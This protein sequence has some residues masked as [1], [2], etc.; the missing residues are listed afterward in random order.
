MRAVNGR[1]R[2]ERGTRALLQAPGWSDSTRTA[3]EKL[4]RAGTGRGLPVAFDFDN[5]IVCGDIG[6]ATMAVMARD[7]QLTKNRIAATLSPS[8]AIPG[9]GTVRLKECADVTEYYAAFLDP[10]R[11]TLK[12]PA[13]LAN[14]YVWAAEIM[15]GLRPLD[16]VQ[17]TQTAF[18]SAR[19]GQLTQI[20]V[21]PGRTAYPAPYFYP[22]MV[23][24]IA[25]L[26]RHK[27][28]V[29]I[30]SA[31]NVWSVRWM[32]LHGLNPRLREHGVKRGLRADH[33]VGVAT[34]LTDPRGRLC[35]DSLLAR[36][37]P[38]YAALDP[39]ALA[40]WRLTSRLQFPAPTYSGKVAAILDLIGRMPHLCAG[41][42]P[43][44]HPMM[45]VA[46]H[47]LWIAR[48]EKPSYQRVALDLL[49][50][51]S[52]RNW[53]VQPTLTNQ[54]PGFVNGRTD[55]AR[56]LSPLPRAVKESLQVIRRF[57]SA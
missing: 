22:E 21:T 46:E 44:D 37:D 36:E 16:I 1:R 52:G 33:V 19:P 41:D 14:G 3:L 20:E 40:R 23:E 28:D 56:R 2:T 54:A 42:S 31:S 13:P 39:R 55:L 48:L 4:I 27:F 45:S 30:V 12:D 9:K 38:A 25:Q 11:H 34:L 15:E 57:P 10:T 8:F 7:R 43:G 35:K 32:V 18:E 17:A 5:T 26:I 50:K 24:L 51:T 49:R 29:W 47:R 6:E 53:I